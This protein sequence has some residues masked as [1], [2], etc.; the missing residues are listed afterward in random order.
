MDWCSHLGATTS[1]NPSRNRPKPHPSIHPSMDHQKSAKSGEKAEPEAPGWVLPSLIR[2]PQQFPIRRGT[3]PTS[4][5]TATTLPDQPSARGREEEAA[6]AASG[7]PHAG[8]GIR[9]SGRA[10]VPPSSGGEE[11]DK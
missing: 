8:V 3:A 6:A 4:P 5:T 10:R 9:A 1:S 11:A 2:V 7:P